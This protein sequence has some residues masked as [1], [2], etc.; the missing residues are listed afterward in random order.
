MKVAR[1]R[2]VMRLRE[3]W[4][5]QGQL[6]VGDAADVALLRNLLLEVEH[7]WGTDTKTW[8]DFDHYTPNQLAP[9]LDTKNYKVVEFSW[10]EKRQDLF[11]GISALACVSSRRGAKGGPWTC[12]AGAAGVAGVPI[13]LE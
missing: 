3:T 12:R 7:T 4:L 11:A 13:R 10:E 5:S 6:R 8:L 2:E 9:M 1:Y